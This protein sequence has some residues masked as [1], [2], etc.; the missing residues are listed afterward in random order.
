M[1]IVYKYRKGKIDTRN[2][3][4]RR[5]NRP[6]QEDTDRDQ[7]IYDWEYY[8]YFLRQSARMGHLDIVLYL[9]ERGAN[10]HLVP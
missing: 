4:N 6:R 10:I 9:I 7:Y 2:R 3:V 1:G 8:D 5:K